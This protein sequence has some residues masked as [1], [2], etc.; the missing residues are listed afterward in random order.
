ML[1]KSK[2]ICLITILLLNLIAASSATASNSITTLPALPAISLPSDTNNP[3]LSNSMNNSWWNK[4]KSFFG[5][6][7]ES[8]QNKLEANDVQNIENS[9]NND[10]PSN[11]EKL[12]SNQL[13]TKSHNF[14][15]LDNNSLPR[16]HDDD[17]TDIEL[18]EL[19]DILKA[20]QMQD[21]NMQTKLNINQTQELYSQINRDDSQK[22]DYTSS[23]QGYQ[24]QI[25]KSHKPKINNT[26]LTALLKLPVPTQS[27]REQHHN[28]QSTTQDFSNKYEVINSLNQLENTQ[29]KLEQQTQT[30]NQDSKVS[31]SL[32]FEEY[33]EKNID[34][35]NS[36]SSISNQQETINSE[37]TLKQQSELQLTTTLNENNADNNNSSNTE[38]NSDVTDIDLTHNPDKNSI[39]LVDNYANQALTNDISSTNNDTDDTAS[40]SISAS[41]TNSDAIQLPTNDNSS[42]ANTDNISTI[43]KTDDSDINNINLDI[44]DNNQ[45]IETSMISEL[46]NH[47]TNINTSDVNEFTV[48]TNHDI[49]NNSQNETSEEQQAEPT[50]TSTSTQTTDSNQSNTDNS[51]QMHNNYDVNN[52]NSNAK[53][54]SEIDTTK[55]KIDIK[56][57]DS[58]ELSMFLDRELIILT[59][60]NDD[61]ELGQ[62]SDKAKLKLI[63]DWKYIKLIEKEI[64]YKKEASK[65]QAVNNIIQ[66][67]RMKTKKMQDLTQKDTYISKCY[68]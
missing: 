17:N 46:E 20:T 47:E 42:T 66:Y 11:N 57:R 4:I 40:A 13:N 60:E 18:A 31:L 45:D 48:N 27:L 24:T 12:E 10:F 28:M 21:N 25:I 63:D 29:S 61:I 9:F 41:N 37:K 1:V 7:V 5:F 65:R 54:E 2:L 58:V 3:D 68:K 59:A 8:E 62:L 38:P 6:N 32:N 30:T 49:N 26:N 51:T 56:P 67:H 44:Q 34:T 14:I 43:L 55:T 23:S 36:L 39:P 33:T 16:L 64:N 52:T 50:S 53:A 35:S 22:Q 19:P 15:T